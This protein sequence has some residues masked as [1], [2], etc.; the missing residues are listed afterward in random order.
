MKTEKE[1]SI[2]SETLVLDTLQEDYKPSKKEN[3]GN[4]C[5][6]LY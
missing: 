6:V 5:Q 1:N 4:I 3:G 2:K